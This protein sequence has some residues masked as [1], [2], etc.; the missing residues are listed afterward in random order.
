MRERERERERETWRD[1]K[2][3]SKKEGKKK[4]KRGKCNTLPYKIVRLRTLPGQDE[5]EREV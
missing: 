5:W 1:R 2:K 4:K 3:E